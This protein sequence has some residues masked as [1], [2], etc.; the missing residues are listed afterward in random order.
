MSTQYDQQITGLQKQYE[1]NS[2]TSASVI[3]QL[4]QQLAAQ[5]A[6]GQQQASLLDEARK[7]SDKQVAMLEASKL[8]EQAKYADSRQQITGQAGS[9]YGKL[10][11]RA[12]QR[13]VQ[14]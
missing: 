1:N 3:D 6:N 4:K 13:S 11:R 2:S 14:Y 5:Q 7:A 9:L 12:Q 8:A 10:R